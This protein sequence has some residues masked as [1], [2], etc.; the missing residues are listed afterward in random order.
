MIRAADI[1]LGVGGQ[2]VR[3]WDAHPGCAVV[4]VA[5][6]DPAKLAPYGHLR[7]TTEPRDLLTDPTIDA[8]SIASYDDAHFEQIR[9]ALEHG[10]HVFAEKPLVL[11]ADEAEAIAALLRAHP[12]LRLSTNVPL[13]RSPRFARVRAAIA[14]GELGE[15]FHLEGDYEYGRRHKLTDGWR[16]RIPYYSV[17][18]GG[19][20]HMV[21]LLLWMSGQRVTEVV[22]A[23]GS[24][25]ATRDTAFRHA[26]FVTALLR[27]EAGATI[28]VNANLGCVHP[29]FHAVRIYGT[30]GTFHNGLRSGTFHWPDRS[31]P[32][33][34]AYPGAA[35]G[36]LIAPFAETIL[37]GAPPEVSVVDAFNALSVCL[38]IDAARESGRRTPVEN[39]L[40]SASA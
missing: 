39:P 15:V 25:I 14:A 34:E 6:L 36:D 2:H 32:V 12:E 7:T 1:G 16:S 11:R 17:V 5:D 24:Q 29:H 26:D 37:T 8:V 31:E 22:A 33:R 10:K 21:D 38:A 9:M 40:V 35:K 19:A 27:T 18:L 23:E 3:G 30:E 13:R 4:A 20:I 28:K